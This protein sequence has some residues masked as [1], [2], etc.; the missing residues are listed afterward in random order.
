VNQP[1]SKRPTNIILGLFLLGG[2]VAYSNII[3]SYFLSDDFAQIG[4]IL[5]GE[6]PDR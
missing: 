2:F 5:G 4:K 3:N 1:G 6:L